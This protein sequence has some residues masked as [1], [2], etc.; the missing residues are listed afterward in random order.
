MVNVERRYYGLGWQ[1]LFEHKGQEY[2]ASLTIRSD[3]NY[4]VECIIFKAVDKQIT[5]ENALG[6][7][8]GLNCDYSPDAVRECVEDFIANS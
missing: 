6:V 7:C 5:F 1:C 8:Y 2:L 3:R 4:C